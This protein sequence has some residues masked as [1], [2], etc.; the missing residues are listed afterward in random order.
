MKLFKNILVYRLIDNFTRDKH[1][2]VKVA[3]NK[4]QKIN[5][6]KKQI[7]FKLFF[8]IFLSLF[9]LSCSN[10][11]EGDIDNCAPPPSGLI[12]GDKN[13]ITFPNVIFAPT[14]EDTE[15]I[16]LEKVILVYD[17]FEFDLV[18]QNTS[19]NSV[20]NDWQE[21]P[22]FDFIQI[23]L[24]TVDQETYAYNVGSEY[25]N[26][27]F[28]S[29]AVTLNFVL[30]KSDNELDVLFSEFNVVCNDVISFTG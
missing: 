7:H 15:T 10:S 14:P 30:N 11:N 23:K 2:V 16:E 22:S 18:M 19:A 21:I 3:K 6:M 25:G 20:Y 17:S 28:D 24:V 26:H 29:N 13:N 9:L 5:E 27:V 8:I 1:L 4:K 12:L